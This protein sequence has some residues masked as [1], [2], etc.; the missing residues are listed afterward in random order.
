MAPSSTRPDTPAIDTV[1]KEMGKICESAARLGVLL[2]P[3]IAGNPTVGAILEE[4]QGSILRASALLNGLTGFDTDPGSPSFGNLRE[5]SGKK[6]KIKSADAGDRRGGCRRR[7]HSSLI[8]MNTVRAKTLDD[9]QTWRK[10]GQ[11]QIQSSEHPRSYFRCTHKFDQNCMAQ[12]Q[13][14]LA[15]DDPK[16]YVI[17]YMGE[18][19]CRDPTMVPHII[20]ASGFKGTNLISFGN[21]SQTIR[22]IKAAVPASFA[23]RK[24]ESDEEVVSNLTSASSSSEYLQLTEAEKP[25]VM[26]PSTGGDVTSDFQYS[27]DLDMDF[28]RVLDL[29][30]DGF[31]S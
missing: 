3:E 22:Q 16:T 19:T 18:H 11:K 23:P 1:A 29:D 8:L 17:T 15:E 26:T 7:A 6:R 25:A 28:M 12:R 5:D 2:Q 9:G 27:G 4:L 31:F 20:S 13:V 10:Y 30:D 21:K 14:Q 24:Q